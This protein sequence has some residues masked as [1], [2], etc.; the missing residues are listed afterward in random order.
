MSRTRWRKVF[1][2]VCLHRGRTILVIAAMFVGLTGAAA[3]IDTW[4]LLRAATTGEY[5]ASLPASFTVTVD[6]V[7]DLLLDAVRRI[8]AVDGVEACR[9]VYG[10]AQR[11]GGDW[12]SAVL[13]TSADLQDQ[14]IA[15]LTPLSGGWPPGD[16]AA[17]IE[18]SSVEFAGAAVGDGLQLRFEEGQDRQLR[19]GA[20]VRDVGLAPG[21]M[22]H[23]IYLFATPATMESLGLG[24]KLDELRVVARDEKLTR[25]QLREVAKLV[26][27]QIRRSNHTVRNVDVPEPG[28]HV[29]AAQ[30]DSLLMTEGAFGIVALLMSGVLIINLLGAILARQIRQIGIM[31]AVGASAGQ[32][33]VMYYAFA[34]SLGGI[35]TA[36]ALPAAAIAGRYYAAFA[37]S[38]LNM[39]VD[40]Y[41]VPAWVIILQAIAGVGIPLLTASI[42]IRRGIRVSVVEALREVGVEAHAAPLWLGKLRGPY[43]PIVLSVRNTFRRRYRMILSLSTLAV[44]GAAFLGALDLRA[45]I[46]ASIDYI[47]GDVLRYDASFRFTS[48]H[49]VDSIETVLKKMPEVAVAEAWDAAHMIIR[50]EDE[51]GGALTASVVPSDS[52]LVSVP[53]RQGRWLRENGE[54]EI[55]IS[56]AVLEEHPSLQLGRLARLSL[57]G[58]D[59]EWMIVGVAQA[60]GP[61]PNAFINRRAFTTVIGSAGAATGVIRTISRDSGSRMQSIL[62]VR[63]KLDSAGFAVSNSQSVDAMRSSVA[64]HLLMVA[65]FLVVMSQLIIVVGGLGLGSAMSLSVM[66][67]GREIA[68]M[69]AIGAQPWQ[70]LAIFETESVVVALMSWLIAVPLSLPIS[71][72]VGQAFGR[73]FFPLPIRLIPEVSALG[74][75]LAAVLV[76]ALISCALPAWRATRTPVAKALAYE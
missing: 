52:K 18:S 61:G 73:I 6:S 32:L 39:P 60:T 65:G 21:W 24:R 10:K 27:A 70:I 13:F 5:R 66:E 74:Q 28:K 75:W 55:V 64:D 49:A 43:R 71:V 16:G 58:H 20:V 23:V 63:E 31:K 56:N 7:D 42:P 1:R 44:G 4:A 38:M 9:A 36:L 53:I 37:A 34:A 14:R 41:T 30:M 29:H 57:D 40:S 15:K 3:V 2:D 25:A 47:Y 11:R 51:L 76:V 62:R 69:R 54:R 22:D 35:A 12:T 17:A 8:P 48:A 50:A 67:R 26:A 59:A 46:R 68:V 33:S 45:S 72:L 19:I